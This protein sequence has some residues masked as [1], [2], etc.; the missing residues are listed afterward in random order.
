MTN[1][2][3][4][5]KKENYSTGW[6]SNTIRFRTVGNSAPAR[7]YLQ[8]QFSFKCKRP[9]W[10]GAMAP[11]HPRAMVRLAAI[12]LRRV[13]TVIHPARL[14]CT[15]HNEVLEQHLS[16][17]ASRWLRHLASSVGFPGSSPF[18]GA[19]AALDP[20]PD[21]LDRWPD[22]WSLCCCWRNNYAQNPHWMLL[23]RVNVPQYHGLI[24]P[25]RI[26]N[27][28]NVNQKL[29][30]CFVFVSRPLFFFF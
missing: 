18:R 4:V 26:P 16:W 21:H 15:T 27:I 11:L 6:I 3:A 28:H 7:L 24:P 14:P 13:H 17:S 10:P 5:W 8:C 29:S 9:G 30:F 1:S 12:G 20:D 22:D 19:L 23:A 25:P 2:V